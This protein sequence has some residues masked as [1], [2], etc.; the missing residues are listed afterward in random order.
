MSATD[1]TT[2]HLPDL[3]T[4]RARLLLVL[5][6]DELVSG[7]RA[8]H[9]TGVAPSLE[10]DL[11][12]STIAQDEINHADVW[13]QVLLGEDHTDVRAGVD[14]LGLGREPDAYLHAIVCERPP[15]DFAFSLARHWAYDRFDVVRLAALAE[16]SDAAIAAVARK[17]LH[18]ERYHL[19]HADHWFGRLANGGDEP[20]Q[21]LH[22][23]LARVLPEALGLFEPFEGEDAAVDAGLLPAPHAELRVRWAEIVGGMLDE[24]GLGDVLPA[25]DATAPVEAAGGRLGRHSADFTDD[26]W[27]EM[28]ALYRAHPGSRW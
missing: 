26:V 12:F 6:D 18:E 7:H 28:T 15:T 13:Y 10:E 23:A 11:A 19:E 1:A 21:R 20:R 9:W 17:L 5:A 4:P 16:S 3:T 24:A 22:D 2:G 27:P 25:A 8:S 14:A